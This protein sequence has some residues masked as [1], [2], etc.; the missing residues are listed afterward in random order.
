MKFKRLLFLLGP[1]TQHLC[2]DS[3]SKAQ[4]VGNWP[5]LTREQP[6]AKEEPISTHLS[7]R[8]QEPRPKWQKHSA[9]F[10]LSVQ[11][12]LNTNY[13]FSLLINWLVFTPL[14]RGASLASLV[15]SRPAEFCSKSNQ[16][17]ACRKILIKA[18]S[19]SLI[20]SFSAAFVIPT[21]WYINREN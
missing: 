4:F 7:K 2:V 5:S 9:S 17:T 20:T 14:T 11:K 16:P 10:Q 15:I 19:L 13:L 1:L 18:I 8:L 3:F 21:I 6:I 12:P